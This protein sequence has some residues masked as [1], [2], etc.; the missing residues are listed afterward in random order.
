MSCGG[1]TL[2]GLSVSVNEAEDG[3][4]QEDVK[5]ENLCS[6]RKLLKG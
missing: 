1:V 6:F 2:R 4:I 3:A 5:K